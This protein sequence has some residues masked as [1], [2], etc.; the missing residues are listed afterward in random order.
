MGPGLPCQPSWR[1]DR[2]GCAWE[3]GEDRRWRDHS[4]PP[5]DPPRSLEHTG[6]QAPASEIIQESSGRG[7]APPDFGWRPPVGSS[8]PQAAIRAG[9]LTMFLSEAAPD[10]S[11]GSAIGPRPVLPGPSEVRESGKPRPYP[12]IS[13]GGRVAGRRFRRREEPRVLVKSIP[14]DANG[15]PSP[16]LLPAQRSA[17]LPPREARSAAAACWAVAHS[18][19][20]SIFALSQPYLS[21]SATLH[22]V[23]REP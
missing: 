7:V 16:Y 5:S 3:D 20:D 19:S 18:G 8:L 13:P 14:K 11:P 2:T 6:C 23:H 10:P 4:R 12:P 22:V 9:A 15:D 1:D 21:Q 17:D